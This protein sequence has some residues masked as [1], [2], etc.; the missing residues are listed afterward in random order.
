MQAAIPALEQLLFLY[1]HFYFK[2]E[3][4]NISFNIKIMPKMHID[5]I[6]GIYNT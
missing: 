4:G 6:L 5:G 1:K 3:S 2:D